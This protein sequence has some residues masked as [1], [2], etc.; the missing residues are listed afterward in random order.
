MSIV[1]LALLVDL[2]AEIDDN[3]WVYI[4][5]HNAL[6]ATLH[7]EQEARDWLLGYLLGHHFGPRQG[8]GP[9]TLGVMYAWR[10]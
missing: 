8:S 6:I 1:Q 7:S 4:L 9:F 5:Q 10:T 2:S 3:G